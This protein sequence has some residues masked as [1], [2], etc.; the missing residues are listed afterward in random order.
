MQ[1]SM[2]TASAVCRVFQVKCTRTISP[3]ADA[4]ALYGKLQVAIKRIGDVLNSPD[5]A[6]RVLREIC[7]LRRLRHPNIIGLRDAF[8]TPSTTGGYPR[9]IFCY[10]K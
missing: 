5:Q 6:K 7:I 4:C 9:Y 1:R 8:S 10:H 2:H 3:V